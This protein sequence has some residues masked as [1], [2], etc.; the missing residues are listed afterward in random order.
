MGIYHC[1]AG[2]I[3]ILT[4]AS[5]ESLRRDDSAF[6]SIP[7]ETFFDSIVAHELAHAAYDAVPCPYSDCL[8]TSEYVAYAM[9]V[10]SLPPPDQKAFAENFALEDRVSRYKISAISLM[11]APD[12]FARNVWAHFSQREDGCAY[13]ADMMRANFYLDTERP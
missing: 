2:R 12:Q 9:Q 3:E 4:P 11:M 5:V 6:S 8:V 10:Y 7:T 1:G 13:V